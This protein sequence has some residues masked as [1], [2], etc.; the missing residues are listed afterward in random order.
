MTNFEIELEHLLNRFNE[1]AA[2]NTPD[3]ILAS[4]MLRCLQAWNVCV[5]AREQWY[6]RSPKSGGPEAMVDLP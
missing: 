5:T 4:Y 2:S 1:E 3:F 6:G